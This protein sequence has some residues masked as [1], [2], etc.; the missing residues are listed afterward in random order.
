MDQ[1]TTFSLKRRWDGPSAF[2][3]VPRKRLC[4]KEEE[5][6]IFCDESLDMETLLDD[7]DVDLP[8]TMRTEKSHYLDSFSHVGLNEDEAKLQALVQREF[9]LQ[10]SG[11][12]VTI[13]TMKLLDKKGFKNSIRR[14]IMK[15]LLKF[16]RDVNITLLSMATS[17]QVLYR[18][19]SKTEELPLHKFDL[20]TVTALWI[21]TKIHEDEDFTLDDLCRFI[22]NRHTKE[23]IVNCEREIVRLLNYSL[24]CSTEVEIAYQMLSMCTPSQQ[25]IIKPHVSMIIDACMLDTELN[26]PGCVACKGV[27]C[28][29]ASLRFV[30]QDHSE[31]LTSLDRV[32]SASQNN[33]KLVDSRTMKTFH[34]LLTKVFGSVSRS[35]SPT[36][37]MDCAM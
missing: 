37:V 35:E 12:S 2:S 25:K 8:V 34:E 31:L 33:I 16:Q 20:A 14:G 22:D 1:Q 13:H 3:S 11:D 4:S 26:I 18:Y 5:E 28:V 36:S 6:L 23:D 21:G 10:E 27:S 7:V 19:V 32:T 15:W 9:A 29:L 17:I 30:N 24:V